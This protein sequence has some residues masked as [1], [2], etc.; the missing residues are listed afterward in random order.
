MRY[1]VAQHC[2][3]LIH[4]NATHVTVAQYHNEAGNSGARI[5]QFDMFLRLGWASLFV[6][7]SRACKTVPHII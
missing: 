1:G 4:M 2:V 3:A 7:H 6:A 5:V